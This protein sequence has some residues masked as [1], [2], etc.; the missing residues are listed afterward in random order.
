ME[1]IETWWKWRNDALFVKKLSSEFFNPF[2]HE[3]WILLKKNILLLIMNVLGEYL[4]K[5]QKK[6]FFPIVLANFRIVAPEQ[7]HAVRVRVN[8]VR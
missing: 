4:L 2:L 3:F 8:A 6:I 5:N 7:Q 1:F